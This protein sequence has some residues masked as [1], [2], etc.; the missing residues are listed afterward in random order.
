LQRSGENADQGGLTCAVFTDQGVDFSRTD[1]KIDAVQRKDTG[2]SAAQ[3][4]DCENRWM[5]RHL[6]LRDVARWFSLLNR[7]F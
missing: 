7:A 3:L 5:L 1:I 6:D 2:K 4:S